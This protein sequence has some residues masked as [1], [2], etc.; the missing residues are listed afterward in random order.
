MRKKI[1]EL[2]SAPPST[3]RN[4]APPP[5]LCPVTTVISLSAPE[6]RTPPRRFPSFYATPAPAPPPRNPIRPRRY[7]PPT[8]RIFSSHCHVAV[9][10]FPTWHCHRHRRRH[11]SPT[12]RFR[13]D[14]ED[15]FHYTRTRAHTERAAPRRI[16]TPRKWKFWKSFWYVYCTR[17]RCFAGAHEYPLFYEKESRENS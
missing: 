4:R 3:L 2:R 6:S 16:K 17:K 10:H 15:A 14:F 8:L 13:F 11:W 9:F 5:P 7:F 12:F 1:F